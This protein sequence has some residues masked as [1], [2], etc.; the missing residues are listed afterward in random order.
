MVVVVVRTERKLERYLALGVAGGLF[1][2]LYNILLA[3][4]V[5]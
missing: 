4:V 5:A 1:E 3:A 2:V